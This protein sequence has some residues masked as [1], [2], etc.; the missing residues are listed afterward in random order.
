MLYLIISVLLLIAWQL[1]NPEIR[2]ILQ[3]L[4]RRRQ[5]MGTIKPIY[6]GVESYQDT[7]DVRL[8]EQTITTSPKLA[9]SLMVLA[10]R[11]ARFLNCSSPQLSIRL[12][13]AAH[14]VGEAISRGQSIPQ[15]QVLRFVSSH[16]GLCAPIPW[17]IHM[18]GLQ[19]DSPQWTAERFEEQ[20]KEALGAQ[21]NARVCL[22][23]AQLPLDA[24]VQFMTIMA[25]SM[26]YIG[27]G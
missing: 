9:K 4:Q 26:P 6:P 10:E 17:V 22:G 19:S 13:A 7:H 1:A 21:K 5:W 11:C 20:L 2:A 16:F 15:D 8:I 12:S 25:T 27:R 24:N 14:W 23:I 3:S 18:Q